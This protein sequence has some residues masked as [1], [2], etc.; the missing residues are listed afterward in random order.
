MQNGHFAKLKQLYLL[1]GAT[2]T[3]LARVK[4]SRRILLRRLRLPLLLLLTL[5]IGAQLDTTDIPD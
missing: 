3:C 2:T 5:P 4:A 1:L